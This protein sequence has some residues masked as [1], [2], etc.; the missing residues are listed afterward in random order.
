VDEALTAARRLL[1]LDFEAREQIA[2]IGLR[3]AEES[4]DPALRLLDVVTDAA[5]GRSDWRWAATAQRAFTMHAPGSIPALTRLIEIC[6]DG[7]LE[8]AMYGAQ[9]MLADAYLAAGRPAEARVIAEDLVVHDPNDPGHVER[10][11]RALTLTNEPDPDGVIARH[12]ESLRPDVA[13]PVVAEPRPPIV[14]T[15]RSAP[16]TPVSRTDAAGHRASISG[17][18]TPTRPVDAQFALSRNAIDI[19]RILDD[20]EEPPPPARATTEMVEVDLSVVL[21]DIKKP[22]PITAPD[23]D[24]AFEQLREQAAAE[25]PSVSAEAEYTRALAFQKAGDTEACIASLKRASRA[26]R[27]QFDA[28]SRLAELLRGTGRI[29]EAVEWLELAVEAPAPTPADTH[30][31]LYELADALE[32][33][34]ESTRALAVC[35]ELQAAAGAYRDVADRIDWL[36]RVQAR[37]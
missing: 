24:G 18:A 33:I 13:E 35:L 8:S 7:D 32:T 16:A 34:G 30:R 9:A 36:T 31:V 37:G 2:S 25:P 1:D 28:A 29:A 19:E 6:V 11:R 4:P 12:V 14:Q 15:P 27:L 3:M 22:M 10:Y 23:L 21:D 20:F 26:P 17:P 5:I